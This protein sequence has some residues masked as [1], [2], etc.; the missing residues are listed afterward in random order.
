LHYFIT[1]RLFFLSG[2]DFERGAADF[3]VD[4]NSVAPETFVC[5]AI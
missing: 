1:E 3:E 4:T 2:L 5:V